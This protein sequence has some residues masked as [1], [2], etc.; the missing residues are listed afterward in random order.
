MGS[1]YAPLP[2]MVIIHCLL[3]IYHCLLKQGRS[4]LHRLFG[5]GSPSP[6]GGHHAVE[7][8]PHG[9]NEFGAGHRSAVGSLGNEGGD[10]WIVLDQFLCFQVSWNLL[11][12]PG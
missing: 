9:S 7:R 6:D 8:S 10:G 11:I 12:D 1:T 4:I 5:R 3:E 2:I